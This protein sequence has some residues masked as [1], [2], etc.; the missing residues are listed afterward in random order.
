M[1]QLS[2][3]LESDEAERRNDDECQIV[4]N[5]CS[6]FDLSHC[7]AKGANKMFHD[8]NVFYHDVIIL[9]IK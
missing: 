2:N 7:D 3:K 9:K 4:L 6:N 5:K 8:E 1:R